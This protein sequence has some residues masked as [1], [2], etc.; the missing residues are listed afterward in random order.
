MM[1]GFASRWM[2]WESSETPVQRTDRTDRRGK[3]AAK[4]ASGGSVGSL[5]WSFRGFPFQPPGSE[6]GHH[7]PL[8]RSGWIWIMSAGRPSV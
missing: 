4:G 8:A 1:T 5:N 7:A 3:K 6:A 2:E